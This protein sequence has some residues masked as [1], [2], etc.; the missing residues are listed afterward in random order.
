VLHLAAL[1]GHAPLLHYLADKVDME[2]RN[3]DGMTALHLACENGSVDCVKVLV[4][5][6]FR[7]EILDEGTEIISL[8]ISK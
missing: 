3:R 4:Q 1:H 2:N 7:K 8:F 6:Y 5:T